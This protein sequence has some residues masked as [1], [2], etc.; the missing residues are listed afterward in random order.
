M[1]AL[2]DRRSLSPPAYLQLESREPVPL[3]TPPA[4]AT[5]GLRISLAIPTQ[6]RPV[7]L[8]TAVRSTFRQ[9][10]VDPARLELVIVDNDAR[11][12]AEPLVAA[13][14]AEAPF[15]VRYVHE[16]AAGVANARNAALAAA[17][18]ELI[19]FLDDDE[20]AAPGWLAA[21]VEAQRRYGADVVFGPVQARAPQA[22]LRHR[23]YLEA[24][25]S[26]EGPAEAGVIAHFYGCGDSL[27]RRAAL[28]HPTAPFP[29]NRNETGGEDDYLFAEMKRAGARF[30]WSPDA[31][32]FEDPV[33]E[34]L[35]LNYTMQRAFAYGQGP[36]YGC[37]SSDPPD[38]LGVARWMAIGLAQAGV[39]GLFAAFQWLRRAP[40]RAFALDRT[41][42]GLGKMFFGPL[43]AQ[44][45][46]GRSVGE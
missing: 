4:P 2:L 14:A 42:R 35:T 25:F 10:G 28:P 40:H 19:A 39:F 13:L 26:R 37:A 38:W 44:K 21:L 29:T 31:L 3:E 6:R 11:P 5:E 24:F 20:E 17:S 45:F 7:G 1:L 27:V 41:M 33:P 15:P 46:Y 34:R 30:A 36:S 8:A 18:G 32:V 16:P 22:V 12:S 23:Q 43:F 9:R